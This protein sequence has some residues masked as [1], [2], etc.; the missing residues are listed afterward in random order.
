MGIIHIKAGA[1]LSHMNRKE[2]FLV[3]SALCGQI[4]LEM[5]MN[6]RSDF[7]FSGMRRARLLSESGELVSWSW[8]FKAG[9]E[10][11]Q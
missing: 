11:G 7:G 9:E 8:G 10:W 3:R 6:T 1:D 4:C 5:M 2:L